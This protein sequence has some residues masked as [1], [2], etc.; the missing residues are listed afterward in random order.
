MNKINLFLFNLSSKYIFI[1]LSIVAILVVFINLIELSRLFENGENS[2]SN[3]IY[4]SF[5]RLPSILN[6]TI[7]LVTIIGVSF[8]LRNLI[9]NNELIS[10][11]N[12]GYSIFDI[13]LP[14]GI[15]VFIIGLVF[16]FLVNPLSIAF[17]NKLEKLTNKSDPS[18]Y[19]IKV[20]NNEMW[21]NNLVNSDYSSFINI[22]N[23]NLQNMNSENI[24]ILII[25]DDN[26]KLIMADNGLFNNNKFILK[27]VKIFEINQDIYKELESYELEI[28]F[29]KENII[30]SI[31]NYKLIPFYKYYTHSNTLKKF[32]LYSPEIGLFYISEILKPF[33][34]VMLSFIILGFSSKFKRNENFF[35]VLFISILIGFLIFLLKEVITKI[36][37]MISINYYLSYSLI[38]I[39]PFLIGLYQVI[40]IENE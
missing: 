35:K 34:I 11:R 18:L 28:N 16:L 20:L 31:T 26:N 7:P 3:L 23:I 38:F 29:S 21:I 25:E 33:F 14:I 36:T 15:S 30:N 10:M 12:V 6:E 39:I 32:N 4:L 22:K 19:S 2:L 27:N 40:K 17:E 8:L 1:N 9:N 37:I 13:F 5:L 24:K